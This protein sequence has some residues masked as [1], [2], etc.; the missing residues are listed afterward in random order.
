MNMSVIDTNAVYKTAWSNTHLPRNQW[1]RLE[2]YLYAGT[3]GATDG[4]ARGWLNCNS[5]YLEV[6]A[7][8]KG[9]F[10]IDSRRFS[11]IWIGHYFDITHGSLQ[12]WTS[13]AYIDTTPARVE[14]GNA[15]TWA[16]CTHREIQIPTSWSSSAINITLNRGSFGSTD[17]V[18]LYVVDA[19]G[20]V[21]PGYAVTLGSG[22]GGTTPP[23]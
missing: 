10:L 8:Q 15:S 22:G 9:V 14:M 19:S 11:A 4:I 12:S 1:Y 16:A 6:L 17:S 23:N 21:S 20:A 13:D 5:V 2:Y 18:C 3:Q 7:S